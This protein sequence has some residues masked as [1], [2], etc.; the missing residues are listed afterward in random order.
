VVEEIN[1]DVV[2]ISA[3]GFDVEGQ[4]I[5]IPA[6]SVR[7]RFKPGD[8]VKVMTGQNAD[9]TGLVVSIADNIVTFL[10]DM[11]MQEVRFWNTTSVSD[12]ES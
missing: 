9:E 2:T 3:I 4:K 8:H 7:K 11:S 5:D 1:Q 12:T 10:S 6:R